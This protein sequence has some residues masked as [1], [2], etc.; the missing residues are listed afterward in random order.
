MYRDGFERLTTHTVGL[1]EELILVDP[2][3]FEPVDEVERALELL[4]DRRFR[5]E[6]RAAHLEVATRPHAT[7][8]GARDELA[9]ARSL[10]DLRLDGVARV[11]AAGVHPTGT[12]PV[13]IVERDR[14]RRIAEEF[15]WAVR[16]GLPSGLHVHVAVGGADRALSV[17]NQA[18]SFLPHIAALAANSPFLH[19]R[20]TGL[21]SARLK[22]NEALPRSGI[23]PRFDSWSSLADFLSWG[24][25]GELIPDATHLWWDLRLHPSYG[26]LEFRVADAQT[27]IEPCGAVAAVCQALVALLAARYDAGEPL[28]THATLRI[29]ENRW[30]ALRH[31]VH[32]RLAD[33]DTGVPVATEDAVGS[34]LASLEPFAERL[35]CRN[36]LLEA[37]TLLDRTGAD[38]QRRVARECGLAGLPRWLADE[39]GASCPLQWTPRREET[40]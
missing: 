21:A 20:D 30:R 39:T 28:P 15:P 31:G 3:R 32:G 9:A 17:Y 36:E 38:E 34:L 25:A 6:F 29:A 27:R 37:W 24:A 1:E 19:G 18:R 12:A 8:G 5:C 11:F 33:L 7:V 23:P 14:Y 2:V 40:G 16:E 35:E 10:A 13:T 22:L 26:T 4:D